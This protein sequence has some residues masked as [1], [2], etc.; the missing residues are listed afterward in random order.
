MCRLLFV[1]LLLVLDLSS[2]TAEPAQSATRATSSEP[3]ENM[4]TSRLPLDS[5]PTSPVNTTTVPP[6][7]RRSVVQ[8]LIDRLCEFG[9][10]LSFISALIDMHPL[11][12]IL[13]VIM[14]DFPDVEFEDEER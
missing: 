2:T 14:G 11:D 9:Q 12:I 10:V 8:S 7:N 6:L 4:P 5:T 1:P 3:L 13:H